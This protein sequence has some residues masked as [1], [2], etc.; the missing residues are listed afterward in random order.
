MRGLA[1]P[2][3]AR[4]WLALAATARVFVLP[5]LW[6]LLGCTAVV[7]AGETFFVATDGSDQNHGTIDSPFATIQ[8]AQS[9]VEPGDT[10]FI[11]GGNY[12]IKESQIARKQRIFAHVIDLNKSGSK[13]KPIRYE[14]YGRE[15]PVFDFSNVK[16]AN[17][18]VHAFSVSGSWL[19]LVGLEV[20]GVQ[21]TIK[22]HT[23]SICFANDGSHNVFERLS[24]HDGHAIG[25][26]AV[27]GSDNLF[28]NCDA[29]R[30]YDPVSE[31]GRGGN[32]DGF[33]CHPRKGDR[34]NVFRGC[35]AWFNSDD[36]FDCIMAGESV[37]FENCWAF[38]N[39]YSPEFKSIADGNGFKAG[40]YGS[41]QRS[42]LPD[43]IPRHVVQKCVAVHNKNSGF[44]ANHHIGGCDWLNNT[45]FR[46]GSN[47]N[48][49][50]RLADNT[51]DVP[52]YDHLL[53]NNLSVRSRSLVNQLNFETSDVA[54][55]SF[56]MGLSISEDDFVAT[57]FA[58]PD[59]RQLAGPR[60]PDGELPRITLLRLRPGSKL[61]DR[62]V[63]VGLP[64]AGTAPDLGAFEVQPGG[65][66]ESQ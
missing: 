9:A 29:Y 18:R 28:L 6:L 53:R 30:N 3:V 11:R 60:Q 17:M 57:D 22:T 37:R 40:G 56:D 19:H 63:D 31:D 39:G 58:Q 24:M 47:F 12:V 52:G 8:R 14:A 51:T 23:Q 54:F 44:Y 7:D 21:V 34:G 42:R 1:R 25:I 27:R 36:G 45:A 35:R 50:S 46:N 38:W 10:V 61:V 49:L 32:V 2:W 26:Y 41:T 5:V 55:N 65:N 20:I 4:P 66:S 16:P 62:G 64:F 33:G 59:E 15:Q 43:P 13:G 48:M